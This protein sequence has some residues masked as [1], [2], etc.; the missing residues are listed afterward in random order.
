M[1]DR[2][3]LNLIWA[4]T[5]QCCGGNWPEGS[6]EAEFIAWNGRCAECELTQ[7]QS[8]HQ[9]VMVSKGASNE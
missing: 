1:N 9:L 7:H 5:C 2:Q 6:E 8:E 3:D 4:A